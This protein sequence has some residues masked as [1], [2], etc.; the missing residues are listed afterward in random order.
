[1]RKIIFGRHGIRYPFP[2]K[3]ISI[4]WFGK[5]LINWEFEN[6]KV[7]TLTD[8]GAILELH[9]GQFLRNHLKLDNNEIKIIC[10]STLRTYQTA[11][12]L[13]M[14]MQ[15]KKDPVIECAD[16][17]FS[18]RD[19]RFD[20]KHLD[21][22]YID[23]DLFS[24][25]D[26]MSK[27]AY[28]LIKEKFDLDK[29]V[30]FLTEETSFELTKGGYKSSGKFFKAASLS[31]ILLAKYYYGIKNDKIF[32]SNNF[33]DDLKTMVEVKDRFIDFLFQNKKLIDDTKTN[34]YKFLKEEFRK[35]E[36]TTLI[37]GH[38]TNISTL[39]SALDIKMPDHGQLEKYPIGSKLIFYIKD[40][41]SFDLEYIFYDHKDIKNMTLNK[42]KVLKLGKNLKLK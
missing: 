7:A 19:E 16:K 20:L 23:W 6:E 42:P 12:L 8:N 3:D 14:G 10:N 31:D 2:T 36:D 32:K 24:K 11:K 9:L 22:S 33:I 13:A 34:A 39:L 27:K 1:M 28:E 26:N 41:D 4:K 5:D 30:P 18:K 40:D 25:F 29:E 21:E 38:N 35:C 37:I 15:P 17:T